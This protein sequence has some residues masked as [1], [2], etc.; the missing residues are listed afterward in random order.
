MLG[1]LMAKERGHRI[2]LE[3]W[4]QPLTPAHFG[5]TGGGL[6]LGRHQPNLGGKAPK[7]EG[8]P[9]PSHRPLGETLGHP[10]SPFPLY[11]ER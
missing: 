3:D 7:F 5:R 4:A 11:I 10:P 6:L 8:P 1:G 9:N 2:P